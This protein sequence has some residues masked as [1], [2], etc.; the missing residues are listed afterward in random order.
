MR[1]FSAKVQDEALKRAE[2][3]CDGCG[4]MLK[5]GQFQFDHILAHALGGGNDISNIQ[6]LCTVCHIA[7]SQEIDN[8]QTRRA[9]KKAKLKKQLPLANGRTEIQRRFGIE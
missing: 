2:G 4:G 7:K 1:G 3:K 8:P 9:D 6:I 5:P